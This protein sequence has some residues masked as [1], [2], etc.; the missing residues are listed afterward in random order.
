MIRSYVNRTKASQKHVDT[1]EYE[2]RASAER[3]DGKHYHYSSERSDN[4][5]DDT[6]AYSRA[7]H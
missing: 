5:S 6:V 3:K 2:L 4:L 7:S 1:E